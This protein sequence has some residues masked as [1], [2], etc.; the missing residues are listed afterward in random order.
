M[1]RSVIVGIGAVASALVSM[2]VFGGGVAFGEG[3]DFSGQT[4]AKASAQIASSGGKSVIAGVVGD[5]LAT[6]D[7]MVTYS[8]KA[9][10]LNA[11]GK[12]GG[13][14]ILLYLNCNNN[15]AGPGKPGNSAGS[16]QG[17]TAKAAERKDLEALAWLDQAPYENC[18]A[19][20]SE[21]KRICDK[22]SDTCSAGL[23][24]YVAALS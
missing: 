18:A 16:P 8:A 6:N 9:S 2:G 22:Y 7:C 3:S 17:Q 14:K 11:S 12:S 5:Q 20:A 10:N 21:C 19:H 13:N 4:Y 1:K 15:L 23:Q 24:E